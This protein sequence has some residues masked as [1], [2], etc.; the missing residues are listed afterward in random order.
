MITNLDFALKLIVAEESVAFV[1][2][3]YLFVYLPTKGIW[4]ILF[5]CM[6]AFGVIMDFICLWSLAEMGGLL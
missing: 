4:N 5:K 1:A 3:A 6:L 2:M